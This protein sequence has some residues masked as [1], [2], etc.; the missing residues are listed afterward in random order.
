[1]LTSFHF[2]PEETQAVRG[3]D[4]LKRP[5][6]HSHP[7]SCQHPFHFRGRLHRPPCYCC[8]IKEKRVIPSGQQGLLALSC[9]CL[10]WETRRAGGPETLECKTKTLLIKMGWD[11]D[12]FDWWPQCILPHWLPVPLL[13]DKK[14]NTPQEQNPGKQSFPIALSRHLPFEWKPHH[15]LGLGFDSLWPKA[16][17]TVRP[18]AHTSWF[19]IPV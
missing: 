9:A 12:Q 2:L 15:L 17:Q 6:T 10:Y 16:P 4:G 19:E 7:L 5:G 1:M 13:K 11:E 8:P 14:A 3:K 18:Q